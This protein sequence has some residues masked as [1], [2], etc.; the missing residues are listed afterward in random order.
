MFRELDSNCI[1]NSLQTPHG[2]MTFPLESI[3]TNFRIS[4]IF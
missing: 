2:E 1:N 3:A 4:C